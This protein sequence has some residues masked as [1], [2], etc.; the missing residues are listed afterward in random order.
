MASFSGDA[1]S[2]AVRADTIYDV[3]SLTKPIVTTTAIMSLVQRGDLQLDAPVVRFLPEWAKAAKSDP[4]PAWRA[5]VTVRM[6]LLHDSGLPAHRDFFKDG[7]GRETVLAQVMAEPL[8]HEP[9]AQVDY[10]DIGFILLGEIVERLTGESLD[11]TARDIFAPL[12]MTDSLFNPPKSLRSRI[13]PYG[14]RYGLP[15]APPA[16]RSRRR[17]CLGHG[18]RGRPRGAFLHRQ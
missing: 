10:S 8:V 14:K 3:A 5:K 16:R 12:R 17:E 11:E 4:N 2:P 15:Q 18:R 7:K 9:G 13:A 1:K 6:L